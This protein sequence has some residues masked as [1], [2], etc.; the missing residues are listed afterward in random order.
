MFIPFAKPLINKEDIKHL[1]IAAKSQWISKGKY[2]DSFEKKLSNYLNTKYVGVTSSGSSAIMLAFLVLGL[3]PG[4]EIIL[5]GYGF[6]AAANV[7][8]TLGLKVVFSDVDA[9]SYCVNLEN[10]KKVVSRKTKLVI[11]IHLYGN[12][13]E[14]DKIVS[15]CKSKKIFLLEDSAQSIGSRFKGKQSGTFGDMGVFSFTATKT[16]T[17]GEGGA[18]TFKSKKFFEKFLLYRSYGYIKERYYCLVHGHNLRMSNLLASIGYSQMNRIKKIE[19][20]RKNIYLQYKN[21]LKKNKYTLQSFNKNISAVPWALAIKL[22][23]GFTQKKRNLVIQKLRKVGIE[24]RNGYYSPNELSIFGKKY[25]L[26]NSMTL[27]KRI[28]SLPY[29]EELNNK[30]I[31]YICKN[32]DQILS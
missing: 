17:T 29:Y 2:V 19:E 10:I 32:L 15:F 7:A 6:L 11:I 3:K 8:K 16:L 9:D 24:V 1:N 13:C 4:D 27:S 5:P 18:I 28:I 26:P 25:N 31:R 23:N 12:M 22:E 20:K 21:E 30:Q 14:V